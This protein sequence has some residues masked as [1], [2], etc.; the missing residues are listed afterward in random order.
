MLETHRCTVKA[1]ACKHTSGSE[2]VLLA[3]SCHAGDWRHES[4]KRF[5]GALTANCIGLKKTGSQVSILAWTIRIH[6]HIS[7]IRYHW[8]HTCFVRKLN[9]ALSN[10]SVKVQKYHMQASQNRCLILYVN[11]PEP[12][13][14]WSSVSSFCAFGIDEPK[15]QFSICVDSTH[16]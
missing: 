7:N 2:S 9:A 3:C 13:A 16:V 11:T 12:E 5:N 14:T 8:Y 1:A 4:T 15:F 6:V 10:W